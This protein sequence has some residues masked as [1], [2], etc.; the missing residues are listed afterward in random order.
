M[1]TTSVLIE[2]LISGLQFCLAVVLILF[3]F[4]FDFRALP[5]DELKGAELPLAAVLLPI[6][7]PVGV[8]VDNLADRFGR[9]YSLRWRTAELSD[10]AQSVMAIQMI[11]R[12]PFLKDY[13][14]YCRIRI[15]ISR[16]SVLNFAVLTTGVV[17][18]TA[19][20]FYTVPRVWLVILAELL[21]GSCFTI[22]ALY[23]WSKITKRQIRALKNAWDVWSAHKQ[24]LHP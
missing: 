23:S 21:I 4:V 17:A 6:A 18:F 9:K 2:F 3:S 22:L 20:N 19:S 16:S 10:P 15:R 7:Y 8:F 1:N 11:T 24:E 12:D 13:F 14:E 5:A